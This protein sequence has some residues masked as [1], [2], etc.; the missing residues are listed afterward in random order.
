[1]GSPLEMELRATK[2]RQRETQVFGRYE[3]RFTQDDI[4]IYQGDQAAI[5]MR[6]SPS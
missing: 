3:F 4:L 1:M 2:I 6:V 5:W